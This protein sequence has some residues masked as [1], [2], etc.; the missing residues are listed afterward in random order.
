[1][2]PSQW[3]D[4]GPDKLGEGT[5]ISWAS[6]AYMTTL[7]LENVA[8]FPELIQVFKAEVFLAEILHL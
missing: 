6:A 2:S 1:M 5:C 3:E 8:F 7:Q 4:E